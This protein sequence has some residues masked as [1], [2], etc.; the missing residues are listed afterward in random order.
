MKRRE[1]LA[2]V[3]A[4]AALVAGCLSESTNERDDSGN[5]SRENDGDNGL[6]DDDGDA[7]GETVGE[8]TDCAADRGESEDENDDVEYERCQK[9]IVRVSDLPEPAACEALTAIEDGEYE[10][11]DELRL[12]SVIAVDEAFLKH[13]DRYYEV[14]VT[15]DESVTSVH[16]QEA[17]PSFEESVILENYLDEPLTV[18]V[19]VEHEE[20]DTVLVSDT[21]GLDTDDHVTLNA[22]VEFPYGTYHAEIDGRDPSET[23]DWE[24]SWE[25]NY[26]FEV[27]H[28]YP[29]QLDEHGIF[30]DPAARNSTYGQC[31]WTDDG[32]VTHH[33]RR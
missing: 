23:V 20:T 2:G 13:D 3:T 5:G 7:F 18:D 14:A 9:R 19:R 4:S 17:L 6:N 11:E 15:T 21:V 28:E 31:S 30:P 12:S 26:A 10:T 29:L 1:I 33:D 32:D 22:D 24:I 25:L 27:G 8:G 16:L